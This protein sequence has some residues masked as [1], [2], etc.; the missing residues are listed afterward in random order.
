MTEQVINIAKDF[1]R[2]PGPRHIEDGPKS[3]EEFRETILAPR[4]ANAVRTGDKIVV[5]LDG[6]RGYTSSFLEEAFG[7]LVRLRGYTQDQLERVLVIRV[8]DPAMRYW[9]GCI[10]EYISDA[11]APA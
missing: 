3:G 4:V 5:V 9:A 6:A 10:K 1:T 8:S 7:G 2:Y 11:H